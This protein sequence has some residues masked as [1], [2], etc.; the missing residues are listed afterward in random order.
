MLTTPP[1]PNSGHPDPAHVCGR[2]SLCVCANSMTVC[3][4]CNFQLIFYCQSNNNEIIGQVTPN[5]TAADFDATMVWDQDENVTVTVTQ[6]G[7]NFKV[8]SPEFLTQ[9]ES[10]PHPIGGDLYAQA[11]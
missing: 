6:H 11:M 9:V 10:V 7:E 5:A 1:E 2:V 8:G 4:F 3:A